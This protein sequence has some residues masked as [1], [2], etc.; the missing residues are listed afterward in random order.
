MSNLS[1]FRINTSK[2][3]RAFC[4]LLI[5]GRLKSFII[6]TSANLDLKLSRINTSKKT[7]GGGSAYLRSSGGCIG[8]VAG[9]VGAPGEL[10]AA[11]APGAAGVGGA[12]GFAGANS[13]FGQ[14]LAWP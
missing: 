12:A 3:F 4:I 2:N 14:N 1:L 8:G 6:N 10:G 5:S 9:G 11:V 7:G 13:I